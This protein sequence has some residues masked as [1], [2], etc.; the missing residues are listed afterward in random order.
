MLNHI[1]EDLASLMLIAIKCCEKTA[2]FVRT[3][4]ANLYKDTQNMLELH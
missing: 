4:F 2:N 3:I 1:F